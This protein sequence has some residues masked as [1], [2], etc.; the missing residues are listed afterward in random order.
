MKESALCR[1]MVLKYSIWNLFI[2]KTMG[3]ERMQKKSIEKKNR[4]KF[5]YF[6]IATSFTKT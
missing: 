1:N 2:C 5:G 3:L 4:F 6:F